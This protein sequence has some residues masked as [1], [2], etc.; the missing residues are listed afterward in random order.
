MKIEDL[1][2]SV[3][4]VDITPPIGSPMEGYGARTEV[5]QGV[6][7]SLFAHL[8][9]LEAGS[10]R[11]ALITLDLLGVR[12]SITDRIRASIGKA[13]NLSPSGVMLA[14]SHTHSGPAG[15]LPDVP[16]LRTYADPEFQQAVERKIIRAAEKAELHL[17]PASLGVACGHVRGV[18]SNRNDPEGGPFDD[19]VIV[20]RLDNQDGEPLAVVM[21]FGCHPTVMGHENLLLSADFPGVTAD[22]L[23]MIYPETAFLFTNGSSGDV[24]TRFT[25]REQTFSEMERLGR[26]L[27]GEVLKVMHEIETQRNVLIA[28]RLEEMNLPLRQFPDVKKMQTK[29]QLLAEELEKLKSSGASHGDVRRVFTQWQGAVGQAEMAKALGGKD[30]IRTQLHLL[31]IDGLSLIGLPGEPFTRTVLEIK[32]KSPDDHT[33]VVSYANDEVGYFPDIEAF[34]SETYEA[35]I[36]PYRKDV[37]AMITERSL[38]LLKEA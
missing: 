5:S 27:A 26:I 21:N 24:S 22:T 35:L 10:E 23:R 9:L 28:H 25:R 16:G 4:R 37:A 30:E 20:L 12:L 31:K 11:A 1:R 13:I 19:E 3:V 34:E 29:I 8:L 38:A 18:G 7:D 14:C 33:A 32:A 17:E 36:S 6:H 15:F 2:A